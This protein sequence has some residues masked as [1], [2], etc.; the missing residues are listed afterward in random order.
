MM[1]HTELRGGNQ[2]TSP[3]GRKKAGRFSEPSLSS[4]IK[5]DVFMFGINSHQDFLWS[6][7]HIIFTTLARFS[8][9]FHLLLFPLSIL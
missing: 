9:V 2:D 4:R 1:M 7:N 8:I 6:N 5:T 3:A